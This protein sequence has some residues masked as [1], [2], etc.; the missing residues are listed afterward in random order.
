MESKR[1]LKRL[2]RRLG[3]SQVSVFALSIRYLEKFWTQENPVAQDQATLD[4]VRKFHAD[5]DSAIK[6]GAKVSPAIAASHARVGSLLASSDPAAINWDQLWAE[7]L[8]ILEAVLP[9]ITNPPAPA[10]A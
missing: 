7:L 1:I 4:K 5:L 2:S 10:G 3:I 9:I 6:S 8:Q